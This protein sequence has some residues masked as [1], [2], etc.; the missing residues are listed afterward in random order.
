M[1]YTLHC[2]DCLDVMRS[3]ADNT[4]DSIVTD[5][6]AG[7]DFMGKDWDNLAN[8]GA[9][10]ER[11]KQVSAVL[12]QL[13]AVGYLESWEAGFLLFT[14]DWA[15]EA[16]RVVKPGANSLVWAIPRTSDLTKF[17]LRLAGWEIR[18]TVYHAFG[19]GFPKSLA[20]DKAIDQALGAK[21]LR[22]FS[23]KNP[24]DRPYTHT[25]GRTSTGWQS[26]VRPEKTHPATE[27]AAQFQGWGT[28]LKPAVEEWILAR[29]PL[30]GTV[31]NNALRHGV[32]GLNIDG[33]RVPTNG[34]TSNQRTAKTKEKEYSGNTYQ[35]IKRNGEGW[36]GNQGRW[37]ANFVHSGDEQVLSLFPMTTSGKPTLGKS[38]TTNDVYGKYNRR[39]LIGGGDTGSAARFFYCAKASKSERSCGGKVD[40][41]H[42][43]VKSLALMKWLCRLVSTP[44][45]G[46]LLDPFM[47][48]GSTIIAAVSEGMT[49]TGIDK[50][51]RNVGIA[52]ARIEQAAQQMPLLG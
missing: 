35:P 18:D 29:K 30:D 38:N 26:P 25:A 47:G 39:S 44:T 20:I 23:H 8:H 34:D 50:D 1:T 17:G 33:C 6:P 49:P 28:A 32:A 4:F 9:K 21:H 43:T 31:A 5:P 51:P 3:M 16:L 15:S 13:Q 2:G 45:G 40:N 11:G 37:P 10:T 52:K 48:S 42:P 12:E 19:S 22:E 24:A 46:K 7:I 27:Q 36:D 14:V 41:D